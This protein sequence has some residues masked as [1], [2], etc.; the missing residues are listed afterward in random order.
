MPTSLTNST[1]KQLLVGL[2]STGKTT[3]T[4]ALW[5]V[6]ESADLPESLQLEA[7][8]G[9]TTYLNSIRRA[10]L[11]CQEMERTEAGFQSLVSM[12][13]KEP[14]VKNADKLPQTA[15]LSRITQ[16]FFPDVDGERFQGQW[17]RR[18]CEQEYATLVRESSGLLLFIHP[19]KV[20]APMTIME[21][22]EILNGTGEVVPEPQDDKVSANEDHQEKEQEQAVEWE[23]SHSSTQVQLVELLQFI[24]GLWQED[25]VQQ[26]KPISVV[27]VLRVAVVISAWDQIVASRTSRSQAVEPAWWVKEHL[28]LLD[29]Y[30]RANP[31]QFSTKFY[32]I[33]AQGADFKQKAEVEELQN[34]HNTAE[35]IRVRFDGRDCH[36]ITEPIRWVMSEVE[37]KV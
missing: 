33:S 15:T 11:N 17:E 25:E 13:L 1:S 6:V 19:G 37:T 16:L 35:R 20:K 29:Q 3:F 30:L 14:S 5:H 36:D 8:D 12:K 7:L 24:V 18:E 4:A 26:I 34:K 32:G 21:M 27:P 22:D 9:D 28:P 2:P 10:W 31:E 23:A